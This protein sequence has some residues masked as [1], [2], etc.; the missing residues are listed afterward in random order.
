MGEA[1]KPGGKKGEVNR[2]FNERSIWK[3]LA[4]GSADDIGDPQTCPG[5]HSIEEIDEGTWRLMGRMGRNLTKKEKREDEE[6]GAGG[7]VKVFFEKLF[8]TVNW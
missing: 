1:H 2:I 8:Q 5:P 3:G 4:C 6:K 7:A